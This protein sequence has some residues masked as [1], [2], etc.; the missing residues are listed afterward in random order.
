MTRSE[1]AR[2]LGLTRQ[3]VGQLAARGMPLDSLQSAQAWRAVHAPPRSKSHHIPPT[4]PKPSAAFDEA[5][6][7]AERAR[8]A[9]E[10]AY[11]A[12]KAAADSHDVRLTG[13]CL[14]D[15]L[16]ASKKASEAEML[17]VRAGEVTRALIREADIVEQFNSVIL[18]FMHRCHQAANVKGCEWY[19]TPESAAHE[20]KATLDNFF[21]RITPRAIFKPHENQT[22]NQ[23]A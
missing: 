11:A 18:P 8:T 5:L 14:R 15:Y 3:A 10:F 17:A 22:E 6:T 7:R 12:L 20:M 9:E 16:A 2:Q 1:L 19:L 21:R 13:R 23:K 4:G